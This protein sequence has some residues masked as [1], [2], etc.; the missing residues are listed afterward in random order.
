MEQEIWYKTEFRYYELSN[1]GLVRSLPRGRKKDTTILKP[2][3]SKRG[4]FVVCIRDCGFRKTVKVH[5]L[6]AKMFIP[7]PHNLPE[8]NH[9][10]ANKL[11]NKIENLEWCDRLH[12]ARHA[13]NLGLFK[14]INY[15]CV[16]TKVKSVNISTGEVR[17]FKSFRQASNELKVNYTSI[18][19]VISGKYKHSNNYTFELV[20]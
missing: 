9:I 5:R 14:K 7:N 2:T 17:Y 20:D 4:Y 15:S 11:N 12:N 18:P 8:V 1:T 10:D 6:V 13:Y 3:I 19:R 16:S